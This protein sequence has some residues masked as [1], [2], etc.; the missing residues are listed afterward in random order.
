MTRTT[1]WMVLLLVAPHVGAVEFD[2]PAAARAFIAKFAGETGPGAEQIKGLVGQLGHGEYAVREKATRELI[3]LGEAATLLVKEAAKNDD[4]EVR[5]RARTVLKAPRDKPK[6]ASADLAKAVDLLA[7][8]KDKGVVAKLIGLLGHPREDVRYAAEYG[9]R[10]VA[11]QSFGYSAYAEPEER[12]AAAGKWQQWWKASAAAFAFD[13]KG[14]ARPMPAGVLISSRRLGKVW[15]VSLAGKVLWE[16]KFEGEL[17]RAKALPNGHI[18]LTHKTRMVVEEYDPKWQVVWKAGEGQ[19]R[20]DVLD[21]QRLPNGNTLVAHMSGNRLVEFDR[22]GKIVWSRNIY[23]MPLVAQRLPNGN[24]L[25]SV[26][27]GRHWVADAANGRVV[28]ITRSGE[29]VWARQELSMPTDAVKLPS[30]NI[31]VTEQGAN[32]VIE[33][34]R[35]GAIVW[36]RKC[37]GR[38]NSARRLPDGTTVINDTEQGI[39]L[40][41]KA[42]KLIR[43]LDATE[44][45]GKISLVPA[46]YPLPAKTE[47]PLM[48]ADERR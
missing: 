5:F 2:G 42:G 29:V 47:Q 20:G 17:S 1:A 22:E 32:R 19:L 12:A 35:N 26:Y 38:P 24:T 31:L 48:N 25:V 7:A 39:L 41:D 9:L 28:E 18:L 8:A 14:P 15:M 27:Y 45:A 3:A 10:R 6:D 23:R 44:G 4:P 21:I 40:V 16:R 11:R 43:K 34:D 30:G 33:L 37:E 13:L 46:G 36:E